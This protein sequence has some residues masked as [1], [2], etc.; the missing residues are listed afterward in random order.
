MPRPDCGYE[1]IRHP[2]FKARRLWHAFDKTGKL[3]NIKEH[4]KKKKFKPF[5]FLIVLALA[6]CHKDRIAPAKTGGIAPT[7][8]FVLNEGI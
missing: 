8:V 3:V 4:K 6:S 5:L 7:G 2:R 1:L